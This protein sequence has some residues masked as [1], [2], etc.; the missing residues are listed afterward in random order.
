MKTRGTNVLDIIPTKLTL[1]QD[2]V[3]SWKLNYVEHYVKSYE[4]LLWW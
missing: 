1:L 3:D 2:E 4:S